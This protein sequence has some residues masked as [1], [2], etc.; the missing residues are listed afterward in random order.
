[1]QK[2]EEHF[3]RQG[4]TRESAKAQHAGMMQSF[5]SSAWTQDD[6]YGNW[7]TDRVDHLYDMTEDEI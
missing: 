3:R 4:V 5:Y 2:V 1:M 7:Y 6:G